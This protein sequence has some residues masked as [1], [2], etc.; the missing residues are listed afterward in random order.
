MQ[1]RPFHHPDPVSIPISV[2][3]MSSVA[4]ADNKLTATMIL[5]AL[6]TCMF[7]SKLNERRPQKL[8]EVD[9]HPVGIVDPA[10][11]KDQ[12]WPYIDQRCL[13]RIDPPERMAK[14][15]SSASLGNSRANGVG[16]NDISVPGT[17]TGDLS[18]EAVATQTPDQA[19]ISQPTTTRISSKPAAAASQPVEAAPIPLPAEPSVSNLA[20]S[21]P[22]ETWETNAD[23]GSGVDIYRHT[24]DEFQHHA[25]RHWGHRAQV[26]FGFR[27]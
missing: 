10:F 23:A 21:P 3:R 4:P 24:E 11:C 25:R 8:A 6:A 13:K 2:M 14:E 12:T 1:H 16:S 27:F 26:I 9:A 5:V 19:V 20:G 15:E 17:A 22:T 18:T 7:L